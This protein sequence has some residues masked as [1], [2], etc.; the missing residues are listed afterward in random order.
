M[1]TLVN[2]SRRKTKLHVHV[3]LVLSG[4]SATSARSENSIIGVVVHTFPILRLFKLFKRKARME[5]ATNRLEFLLFKGKH[6]NRSGKR[7]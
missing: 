4:K 7:K 3:Y 5:I 6:A 2:S 1:E